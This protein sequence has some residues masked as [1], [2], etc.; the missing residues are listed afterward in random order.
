[1]CTYIAYP[2]V[3]CACGS[4]PLRLHIVHVQAYTHRYQRDIRVG[5]LMYVCSWCIRVVNQARTHV[6][7]LR[8]RVPIP[9]MCSYGKRIG[10]PSYAC[11]YPKTSSMCLRTPFFSGALRE[12][13]TQGVHFPHFYQCYAFVTSGGRVGGGW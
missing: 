4:T 9:W 11:L 7:H 13:V 1:M 12:N 6:A 2:F 5:A 3:C 8:Y 10:P